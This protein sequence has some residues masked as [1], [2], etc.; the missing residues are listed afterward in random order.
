[1]EAAPLSEVAKLGRNWP[2]MV[3][4]HQELIGESEWRM[5]SS[6]RG[7]LGRCRWLGVAYGSV[8]FDY[9]GGCTMVF[10]VERRAVGL[11]LHRGVRARGVHS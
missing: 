9:D 4:A 8:T 3:R 7:Y 6:P 1:M 10:V 2:P 5:V 11:V